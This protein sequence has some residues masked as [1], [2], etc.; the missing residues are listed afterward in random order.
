MDLIKNRNLQIFF[1]YKFLTQA[2]NTINMNIYEVYLTNDL[3]YPKETLAMIKVAIMP[4]SIVF[5][6]Y[7]GYLSKDKPF[8][9][10]SWALLIGIL[11]NGYSVLVILNTFP[12]K[13]NITM[14]TTAHVTILQVLKDFSSGFGYVSAYSLFF[15]LTDKR[16]A[17]LHVTLLAAIDNQTTFLHKLY[18]F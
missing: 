1:I 12:D 11:L 7:S 17:G 14:W 4:L 6:I 3:S 16:I 18:I 8:I 10:Q 9:T 15:Q 2:S 13:D 5:M